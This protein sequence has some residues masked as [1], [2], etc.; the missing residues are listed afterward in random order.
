MP[1]ESKKTWLNPYLS[2]HHEL[3]NAPFDSGDRFP[4]E[5]STIE[6]TYTILKRHDNP[7]V[8]AKNCYKRTIAGQ[9]TE[10]RNS[11]AGNKY[12]I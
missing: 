10:L 4:Y 6:S 11:N 5:C 3:M 9:G 8:I 12:K 7:I 2:I 1:K